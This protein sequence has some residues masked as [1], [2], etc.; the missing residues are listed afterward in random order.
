MCFHML[1]MRDKMAQLTEMVR[2][3]KE[4]AQ[5]C[6]K[7]WYD[8]VA[9]NGELQPGDGALILLPT[10]DTGLLAKWQ[11]P[12]EVL[13]K[14]SKTTYELLLPDRKKH[15]QTFHVNMLRQ[16]REAKLNTAEQLWVRAYID[17]EENKEQYFPGTGETS[18][19][20][21]LS[22]LRTRQQ[23]ELMPPAAD[24]RPA[25]GCPAA[26]PLPPAAASAQLAEAGPADAPSGHSTRLTSP[27]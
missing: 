25:D 9:K 22:Q 3:N 21:E 26:A 10:S 14:I 20:L 15:K 7:Q 18:T 16:W 17:E 1:K 27:E 19:P 12:Y 11:G 13:R 8:K 6:Q 2:G 5:H 24:D 4:E 23:K